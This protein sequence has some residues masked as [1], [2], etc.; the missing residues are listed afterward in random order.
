[1]TEDVE[2]DGIF[3]SDKF[4]NNMI[5]DVATTGQNIWEMIQQSLVIVIQRPIRCFN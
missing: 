3:V 5:G 4:F 1:M 2:V